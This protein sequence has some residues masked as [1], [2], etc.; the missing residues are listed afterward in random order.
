MKQLVLL[1]IMLVGY[2]A[3]A[4]TNFRFADSTA[5]W[6]VLETGNALWC[7]CYSYST[8]SRMALGDTVIG[9]YNYQIISGYFIR[10]DSVGRVF[11]Y[12]SNS[13]KILYNFSL[14]A[15]DTLELGNYFDYSYLNVTAYIDSTDSIMI[16]YPRKRL[17]LHY[18]GLNGGTFQDIW[19]EGIGSMWSDFL[20]PGVEQMYF[21]GPTYGTRCFFEH[22]T[23]KYPQLI[24]W[25]CTYDTVIYL[26]I[27]ASDINVLSLSPNPVT[28]SQFTV[29]LS[30]TPKPNTAFVLYDA[31]GSLVRREEL[32]SINQTIY[33]SGLANGMYTYAITVGDNKMST[34]K[35]VLLK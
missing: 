13:E 9:S 6:N 28:Q 34:G 2:S 24:N 25:N 17:Y 3:S 12:F 18:V 4:Q 30:E 23:L 20:F 7:A 31:V 14:Q 19:I 1:I 15:G 29:T 16:D 22:D 5:Q 11:E 33:T 27:N 21:D 26:D 8:T 10:R 32:N 35:L